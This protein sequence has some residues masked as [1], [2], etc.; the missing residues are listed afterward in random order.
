M[1]FNIITRCSR[2]QNLPKVQASIFQNGKYDIEWHILFDT[3]RL[4]DIPADLLNKLDKSKIKLHFV[5]GDGTDYLYP[6]MSDLAKTFTDGFVVVVDDDN[7]VHPQFY[8]EVVKTIKASDGT[9]RIFVVNQYVGGKDFTGLNV[10]EAKPENMKYQGVD[11]AQLIFHHSVF[12]QYDFTGHYAGDGILIDKIY[13]EQPQ[14]FSYIPKELCYYNHLETTPK[15]NIPTVLLIADTHNTQSISL[16]SYK[17]ND[18]EDDSLYTI[19]LK[20]DEGIE[21]TIAS[22]NPDSIIG[23]SDDW[24]NFPNLSKLPLQ[25]RNKWIT[26][27]QIDENT[28]QIAYQCAMENIL[29]ND[30]SQLISYFTPIYNTGITLCRTYN[31]L[32]NQTYNNWEW[33]LVNDSTD[34]G[35]TLKIAEQI[36]KNDP[37]VKVYDFRNKSGGI[38]G[39]VK[40]RAASLCN[41]YILA[42]LDHDDYL[43][44]NCTELLYNASKKHPEVG[45]FYSDSAEINEN[46]DSLHY[47]PGFAFGYGR[48]ESINVDGITYDSCISPNINPKT[49]RHIVGVPNHVRAWRR[50][51]YHQIKGHNRG[52]SVADDY[53]LII[54]TF[55][56]TEMMRIPT[57]C[58]LQHIHSTNTTDVSRKDIQRRVRTIMYYYNEQIAE[59][60]KQL[61][62]E[63]Y[64]YI[65]NPNAPLNVESRFGEQ[66]NYVNKIYEL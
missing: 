31:S 3:T 44:S 49:I 40:Y 12:Q 52:L 37:R 22:I 41:G 54:R 66:E 23:I 33:V 15:A 60:F 34:G 2:L 16:K 9:Q 56:H 14:W 32:L 58:Y 57:L 64:C 59:R 6:Q 38:I 63:D 29:N 43:T 26:L 39:E 61:G 46:H 11:I 47:A 5:W 19:Q 7:I 50:E 18:Y 21:Q 1:K 35:K 62:V 30:N 4:K 48:Y 20:N 65:E 45:F 8:H 27:P 13:E 51:V 10:R 36:A 24:R 55:L 17:V 53:E 25:V 42:E 28:G